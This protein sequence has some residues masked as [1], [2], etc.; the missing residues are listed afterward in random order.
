MSA[1]PRRA[2]LDARVLDQLTK[3]GRIVARW[4]LFVQKKR[5]EVSLEDLADFMHKLAHT[6]LDR[7]CALRLPQSALRP[8]SLCP[9]SL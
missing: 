9:L 4:L 5:L 7:F 8:L 1:D 3:E 2:T 6:F